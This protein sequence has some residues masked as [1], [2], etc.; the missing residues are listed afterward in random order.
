MRAFLDDIQFDE[1]MRLRLNEALASR[2]IDHRS[3]VE[4]WGAFRHVAAS[5][6]A[7]R[8]VLAEQFQDKNPGE[9]W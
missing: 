1:F 5:I 9:P 2:G 6:F 8:T 3:S 7:A 4:S